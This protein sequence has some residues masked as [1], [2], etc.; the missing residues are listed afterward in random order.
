VVDVHSHIVED[1]AT[2]KQRIRRALEILKPDQLWIDPDC[3]LKTRTQEETI[4]KLR[5]MVD[6]TKKVRKSLT[7]KNS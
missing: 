2:V 1:T 6:A 5:A 7:V 4:G 3:G